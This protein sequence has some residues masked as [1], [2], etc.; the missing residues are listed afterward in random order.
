MA[1]NAK[2]KKEWCA[3]LEDPAAVQG[4]NVLRN[5]EGGQCCLDFLNQMASDA[6]IQDQPI[7]LKDEEIWSYDQNDG[8]PVIHETL[9][10]TWP[11]VAWAGLEDN[12]PLVKYTRTPAE[13]E[14]TPSSNDVGGKYHLS[15][16]NDRLLKTLP[17]IA[18]IIRADDEL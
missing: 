9:S 14:G 1:M 10:L 16:L 12:D 3:K 11:T 15:Y 17:E 18:A 13:K 2:I 7:F 5:K 8:D 6:G 4:H